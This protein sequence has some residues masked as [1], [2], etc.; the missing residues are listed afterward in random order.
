MV[1]W[2]CRCLTWPDLSICVRVP[3]F[4]LQNEQLSL[5]QFV[6]MPS[7]ER[8]PHLL[9]GYYNALESNPR[10]RLLDCINSF[11]GG[12]WRWLAADVVHALFNSMNTAFIENWF[13]GPSMTPRAGCNIHNES[14]NLPPQNLVFRWHQRLPKSADGAEWS[15]RGRSDNWTPDGLRAYADERR[16]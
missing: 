13:E 16:L 1:V 15:S 9:Q 8:L 7:F 4:S 3:G 10:T 14:L 12:L 5:D 6:L 11:F 2:Q